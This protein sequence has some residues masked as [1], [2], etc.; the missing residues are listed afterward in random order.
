MKTLTRVISNEG[1]T[2]YEIGENKQ[3]LDYSEEDIK[4]ISTLY[5]KAKE[6]VINNRKKRFVEKFEASSKDGVFGTVSEG[7]Y[8]E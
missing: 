8:E 2:E 1:E 4:K 7:G 5:Q 3:V 6:N